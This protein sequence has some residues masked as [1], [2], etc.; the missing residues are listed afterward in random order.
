MNSASTSVW[1]SISYYVLRSTKS[2]EQLQGDFVE[3]ANLKPC[4]R[5]ALVSDV[6]EPGWMFG[7]ILDWEL[8]LLARRR[9]YFFLRAFYVSILLIIAAFS[10]SYAMSSFDYL[11]GGVVKPGAVQAASKFAASF[12]ISF[13]WTQF[14]VVL[15]LVPAYLA[16]AIT[17]DR[18]RKILD[19][20]LASQLSDSE[21]VLGRWSARSLNLVW[22]IL[23]GF[24]VPIILSVIGGID[25]QRILVGT[26][27]VFA[28]LLSTSAISL[29]CSVNS[30]QVRIAM[31]RAYL[32]VVLIYM[33]Q[34]VISVVF[35]LLWYRGPQPATPVKS[36][37][38]TILEDLI[39]DFLPYNL[40]WSLS[41]SRYDPIDLWPSLTQLMMLHGLVTLFCLGMAIITLRRPDLL[42]RVFR[43]A[44]PRRRAKGAHASTEN[45]LKD[46]L[47]PTEPIEVRSPDTAQEVTHEP[48]SPTKVRRRWLPSLISMTRFPIAWREWTH[49]S[50][51]LGLTFN[52][53]LMLLVISLA[54]TPLAIIF[55]VPNGPEEAAWIFQGVWTWLVGLTLLRLAV[56]SA[57][58]ISSERDRD[59]LDSILTAPI[60]DYEFV[61]GKIIGSLRPIFH[62]WLLY[63]PV[64]VIG[65]SCNLIYWRSIPAT[66]AFAMLFGLI[67][68]GFGV[69]M[70]MMF[71]SGGL[72]MSLTVVFSL[73][74]MAIGQFLLAMLL[75]MLNLQH[76]ISWFLYSIP[77]V[78][79]WN[80]I[81]D[82]YS[83]TV[84]GF[85]GPEGISIAV[86]SW[87][88]FAVYLTL[89]STLVDQAIRQFAQRTGRV[90]NEKKFLANGKSYRLAG[91]LERA[92]A[93]FIDLS[94]SMML[95]GGQLVSG[96]LGSSPIELLLLVTLL[97]L[98]SELSFQTTPGKWLL[99]L[100]VVPTGSNR[101][102][103]SRFAILVRH[104]GKVPDTI[105]ANLGNIMMLDPTGLTL[106]DRLS[107]TRV[108]QQLD[109][110]SPLWM[111][112]RSIKRVCVEPFRPKNQSK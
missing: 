106:H 9:R 10:Y 28:V 68:S 111:V 90:S 99:G 98:I 105:L 86:L 16:P 109:T 63:L 91:F 110:I 47:P 108:A 78:L 84:G 72:A 19:Y 44:V 2:D 25:S 89:A 74:V 87:R 33:S 96:N 27:V 55:A 48:K 70:S 15:F 36:D 103:L 56:Q 4:I 71:K 107:W 22:L 79:I 64:M 24:A 50:L 66:L 1:L 26:L 58:S 92:L 59:C 61:V 14:I 7:P 69:W 45:V 88:A 76:E 46:P 94:L 73:L 49:N 93:S 104:I 12:A 37:W 54:M 51:K 100:R 52:I 82:R 38:L 75:S 8:T 31:M 17:Q 80:S 102:L 3:F 62:I 11:P 39:S 18:E 81:Y 85:L 101:L 43:R 40:L 95:A 30:M 42:A 60:S 77:L 83:F 20:L 23:A 21:I 112:L 29:L 41:S 53:L 65:A 57:T 67:I 32:C 35:Y 97:T 6:V 13:L 5:S 34:L